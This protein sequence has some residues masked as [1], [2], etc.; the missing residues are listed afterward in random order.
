MGRWSSGAFTRYV[1]GAAVADLAQGA[2]TRLVAA[3]DEVGAVAPKVMPVFPTQRTLGG[4]GR[5][6]RRKAGGVAPR[7]VRVRPG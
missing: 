3:A 5:G 2:R 4:L 7:P 6:G 1:R